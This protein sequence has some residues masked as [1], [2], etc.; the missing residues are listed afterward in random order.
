MPDHKGKEKGT[1][2][3]T[4]DMSACMKMMERMMGEEGK[5]CGCDPR[6][7]LDGMDS[8]VESEAFF[9]DMFSTM[10][11]RCG[12]EGKSEVAETTSEASTAD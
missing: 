3:S 4:V 8:E 9:A 1:T 10:M 6:V 7:M 2:E 5:G 11:S 12:V